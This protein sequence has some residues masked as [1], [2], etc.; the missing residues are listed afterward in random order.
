MSLYYYHK[1]VATLVGNFTN[2]SG[3]VY[4]TNLVE[5]AYLANDYS[6]SAS[7]GFNNAG[8]FEWSNL[9]DILYKK[10]SA[11][12]IE[13]RTYLSDTTYVLYLNSC[14][15]ESY[16]EQGALISK[17]AVVGDDGTYPA[18]GRYDGFWWIKGDLF[19]SGFLGA[20]F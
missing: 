4:S 20:N 18:D 3:W 13:R 12:S 17:N 11:T 7:V 10:L 19:T 6:F 1:Y 14:D 2:E 8:A 16:Y 9:D 5:E 15:D